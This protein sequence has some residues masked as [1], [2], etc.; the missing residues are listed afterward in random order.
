MH[1][2]PSVA[3]FPSLH[4]DASY[5]HS[6]QLMWCQQTLDCAACSCLSIDSMACYAM[7]CTDVLELNGYHLGETCRG[8]C[9]IM[10]DIYRTPGEGLAAYHDRQQR[11][12][13]SKWT[14]FSTEERRSLTDR[15]LKVCALMLVNSLFYD[16]FCR[17]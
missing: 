13:I 3:I 6:L 9:F 4:D 7:L 5:H 11:E 2:Q 8:G 17:L 14:A 10:V 16:H 12:V 1:W 15:M